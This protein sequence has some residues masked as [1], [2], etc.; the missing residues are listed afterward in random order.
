M[1]VCTGLSS[2]LLFSTLVLLGFSWR[3]TAAHPATKFSARASRIKHRLRGATI[4]EA[5]PFHDISI[6]AVDQTLTCIH[7][8][9]V[10]THQCHWFY[11]T[12]HRSRTIVL[13]CTIPPTRNA[14]YSGR[15]FGVLCFQSGKIH[16]NIRLLRSKAA[17]HPP[18]LSGL[19]D[20][21]DTF[22]P[23]V[24]DFQL[25]PTKTRTAL[26]HQNGWA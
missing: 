5:L 2:L 8:L 13:S 22:R 24:Q 3:K 25:M 1:S 6:D 10:R 12:E 14:H 7:A 23:G 17:L 20:M 18:M 9:G 15:G 21:R 19:A 4:D 26:S 11:S 16:T